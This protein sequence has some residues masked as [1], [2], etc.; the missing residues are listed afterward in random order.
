MSKMD[1]I[2]NIDNTASIVAGTFGDEVVAAVFGRYGATCSDN[3]NPR[4]Y[5]AVF[6][7]LMVMEADI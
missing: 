4:Y 6:S 1:W 3:L 5:E 2:I 7:D